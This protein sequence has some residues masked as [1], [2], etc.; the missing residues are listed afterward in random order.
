MLIKII[1]TVI[2]LNNKFKK[3]KERI[4][5][6]KDKFFEISQSKEKKK[7]KD[8]LQDMC[9]TMRQNNLHIMS[10]QKRAEKEKGTQSLFK[11]ILTENTSNCEKEMGTQMQEA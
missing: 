3:A 5:G 8:D 7:K 6:L 9:G 11:E 2:D 10:V 4:S 1:Y